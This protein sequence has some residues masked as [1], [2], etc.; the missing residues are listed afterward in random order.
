MISAAALVIGTVSGGL[1][2]MTAIRIFRSPWPAAAAVA[3]FLSAPLVSDGLWRGG[4]LSLEMPVLAGWLLAM[5]L[6]VE[7]T[8]WWPP[9]VAGAVASAGLYTHTGAMVTMPLLVIVGA[10][11]VTQTDVTGARGR[12]ILALVG[13]FLAAAIPL[14]IRYSVNP[15]VFR[16]LVLAHGLYDASRFNVLQGLRE[17]FS[18]VG[19]VARTEVY[20][21]FFNPALWFLSGASVRA[22]VADPRAFVVP[23]LVLVPAGVYALISRRRSQAWLVLGAIAIAPVPVALLARRPAVSHLLPIA[24]LVTLLAVAGAVHLVSSPN[25]AVRRLGYSVAALVPLALVTAWIW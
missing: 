24:P 3:L 7:K 16:N 8:A 21:D 23:Y 6:A 15:D 5:Q 13:A 20:Y 25:L 4:P 9:L 10:L 12:R 11:A 17:I 1:L 19:L 2:G 14:L 18:W 22:H